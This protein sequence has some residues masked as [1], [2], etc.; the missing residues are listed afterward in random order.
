MTRPRLASGGD[1]S[2][3]TDEWSSRVLDPHHALLG[4]GGDESAVQTE[5]LAQSEASSTGR[6]GR[7]LLV[8][9]PVVDPAGAVEPHRVVQAGRPQPGIGPHQ[10]VPTSLSELTKLNWL[11]MDIS[12]AGGAAMRRLEGAL[13]HRFNST[14]EINDYSTGLTMVAQGLGY[15]L[16]P[17]LALGSFPAPAGVVLHHLTGLGGRKV[18]L[19]HRAT[20]L[21]P[22]AAASE[23]IRL[24]TAKGH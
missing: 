19:R 20:R 23:V 16:V 12:T 7:L 3:L 1:G 2:G 22:D 9:H 21:E 10:P 17:H 13:G 18:V 4:D 15:C 14:H 11:D 24:L 8:E 5:D 6:R